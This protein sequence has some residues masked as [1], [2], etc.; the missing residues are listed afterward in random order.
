MDLAAVHAALAGKS[1]S[2]VAPLCDDLFLQAASRGA[3][4]D[5]WPYAVHLLAHLYLNDLN[6]ARFLWKS[7]PQEA[8][9]ARP[10]LAAVWRIGQCLW[11]RDYA[12][13]Y[14]AAQ[15]F[16]W[17]PEIADFV[18]AFL[19]SYRK[20]IFQLL[21]SA[22]STISVADVAHFMGMNEEDATN[23]AMQNGWSLDAAARMLTVVKPKVKTNQ[24]LDASKLQRLTE[25]VFHLEH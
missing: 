9:D 10:E 2:S 25:C 4:T 5:G 22:Y 14:A 23:Y 11:N 15:G 1:Y 6:S 21:T 24:K 16:E 20:R 12:G 7:T 19:E 8:K 3:A 18:A 17:S 13:V